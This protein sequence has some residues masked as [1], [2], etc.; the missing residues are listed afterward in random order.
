MK[1]VKTKIV[2]F[3]LV[4]NCV[5]LFAGADE[6]PNTLITEN[7]EREVKTIKA[8]KNRESAK[9]SIKVNKVDI[10]KIKPI[11]RSKR[12][13]QTVYRIDN[14]KSSGIET[15]SVVDEKIV[16]AKDLETLERLTDKNLNIKT[17]K[18]LI[19]SRVLEKEGYKEIKVDTSEPVYIGI[20][21]NGELRS[22]IQDV[23]PINIDINTPEGAY[24]YTQTLQYLELE[25]GEREFQTSIK[26]SYTSGGEGIY[27]EIGGRYLPDGFYDGYEQLKIYEF[28][29]G[30]PKLSS[31]L[32][33]PPKPGQIKL[34]WE[35]PGNV[36]TL[37]GIKPQD[38][39][40]GDLAAPKTYTTPTFYHLE[41][42]KFTADVNF[43]IDNVTGNSTANFTNIKLKAP[44]AYIGLVQ[45]TAYGSEGQDNGQD[46]EGNELPFF[47]HYSQLF[48]KLKKD[49]Q[50]PKNTG[51]ISN[52]E[53]FQNMINFLSGMEL[54]HKATLPD[55]E[56]VMMLPNSSTS[57]LEYSLLR[58]KGN[59]IYTMEDYWDVLAGGSNPVGWDADPLSKIWMKTEYNANT[60]KITTY[61]KVNPDDINW[62]G[63]GTKNGQYLFQSA[64][65]EFNSG[66]QTVQQFRNHKIVP[67][68]SN[69]YVQSTGA[70]RQ[71]A[72]INTRSSINYPNTSAVYHPAYEPRLDA[73][74]ENNTQTITPAIIYI[75]VKSKDVVTTYIDT[76][77]YTIGVEQG[78]IPAASASLFSNG[79]K[80]V[81]LVYDGGMIGNSDKYYG[82]DESYPN[83]NV[84][85]DSLKLG[86]GYGDT[87]KVKDVKVRWNVNSQRREIDIN[88]LKAPEQATPS[89]IPS[90]YVLPSQMYGLTSIAG[91]IRFMVI[92]TNTA[93]VEPRVYFFHYPEEYLSANGD[94]TITHRTKPHKITIDTYGKSGG[95]GSYVD[96][97]E[98][99]IT[100]SDKSGGSG[101]VTIPVGAKRAE[102]D[103]LKK[104]GITVR[105]NSTTGNMI[106]EIELVWDGVTASP[107]E[108]YNYE[109]KTTYDL[110]AL[111][112]NILSRKK[113]KDFTIYNKTGTI[114]G[115][116]YLKESGLSLVPGYDKIIL[117]DMVQGETI[118]FSAVVGIRVGTTG[119]RVSGKLQS[120]TGA[121]TLNGKA[122]AEENEKI[123]LTNMDAR[124]HESGLFGNYEDE[125]HEYFSDER[126]FTIKGKAKTQS[127]TVPG[128]YRGEIWMNLEIEEYT[129]VPGFPIIPGIPPKIGGKK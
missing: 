69:V 127:D 118:D 28:A 99:V 66:S 61:F 80:V 52:D 6:V 11:S 43:T 3:F 19:T 119:M 64:S 74:F 113:Y 34:V 14:D 26:T 18:E 94:I 68:I 79:L 33:R 82:S 39:W 91:G 89:Y 129:S 35:A 60:D 36:A 46:G 101:S 49:E 31:E 121:I 40:Q 104:Y 59:G 115:N 4:L 56:K 76:V 117:P 65:P 10:K 7:P 5:F 100:I 20:F 107:A 47:R 17:L 95:L 75:P 73:L 37:V 81:P 84:K 57:S 51:P 70:W 2:L 38:F 105:T 109:I 98:Y 53:T 108:G 58:D 8:P 30:N 41:F 78:T 96:E 102:Y 111:S 21:R 1:K 32:I 22:V 88:V 110:H 124:K 77:P 15:K 42:D 97:G 112:D 92:P 93:F 125:I 24:G 72:D 23:I 29:D 13:N 120:P 123:F 103:E 62:G 50:T 45:V 16:V 114:K 90:P 48:L 116:L 55:L 122:G 27:G 71:S 25:Q 87:Q 128:E 9:M 67:V 63:K 86:A 54:V 126:Y 106:D 83:F 12:K 44:Y 85:L